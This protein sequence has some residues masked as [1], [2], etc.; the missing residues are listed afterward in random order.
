MSLIA[1]VRALLGAGATAEMIVAA[2][3]A[4]EA[5]RDDALAK[6]RAAD[7]ARQQA[8]R[9][10]NHV[11]SR[12]VTTAVSGAK[13]STI[14]QASEPARVRGNITNSENITNYTLPN[15]DAISEDW[16][17]GKASDHAKLICTE[18]A[19]PWLDMDKSQGLVTTTGLLARWKRNG[20]SWEHDVLPL[21]RGRLMNRR[22]AV[23]TWGFFDRA[24][25]ETIAANRAALLIPEAGE[26][27]P[28][29]QVGPPKSY[30]EQSSAAW[31]YAMGKI[32]EDG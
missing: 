5:S 11:T 2:V 14:S 25:D 26:I 12:D 9:D 19:S 6:R 30:A 24:I 28:F 4:H 17:E 32:A 8:K 16:P 7:A 18:M 20:A 27:I 29:R 10:R 22:Q 15:A 1:T 23:T 13:T 3:E 21:I 31:D